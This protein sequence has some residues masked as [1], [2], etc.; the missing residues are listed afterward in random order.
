M[1]KRENKVATK[2]VFDVK[3]E[4]IP[5]DAL[6]VVKISGN[7]SK[8]NLVQFSATMPLSYLKYLAEDI[9][10]AMKDNR[11]FWRNIEEAMVL[12]SII[13]KNTETVIKK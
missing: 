12:D 8:G 6:A 10:Q 13:K 11:D 2:E 4:A 7:N 9:S 1:R 5:R 3:I